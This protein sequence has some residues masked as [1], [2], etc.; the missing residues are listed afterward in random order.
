[1]RIAI[2]TD[3]KNGLA[4]HVNPHFGRCPHYLLVDVDGQEIKAFEDIDNP[5]FRHHTPG[6]IPNF[7][8]EQ[9]AEVMIAGGMGHRAIDFF[10]NLGIEAV[11]GASGTALKSLGL[12]LLGDLQGAEPCADSKQHQKA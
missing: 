12:Y 7:I 5:F 2:A 10:Q 1:M 6:Q 8:Q 4:S 11:S 3:S 9:G